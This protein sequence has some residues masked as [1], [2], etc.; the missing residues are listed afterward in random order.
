MQ[1]NPRRIKA[2]TKGGLEDDAFTRWRHIL[3]WGRGVL[4]WTKRAYNK[5]VRREGKKEQHERTTNGR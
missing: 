5:R 4:K 3:G 2:K 1:S